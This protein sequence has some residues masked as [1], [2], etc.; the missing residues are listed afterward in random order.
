MDENLFYSNNYD[1]FNDE[2]DAYCQST[3]RGAARPEVVCPTFQVPVG[4]GLLIAGGNANIV[5]DNYF[6]D[7]WRHGTMLLWV[8]GRAARRER[9]SA[10][11][12][13]RLG[14]QPLRGQLHG[15]APGGPRPGH[16]RL[17]E[18]QGTRDPNGVDFWWDEEEGQDCDPRPGRAASTPTPASATAGAA[19]G[20]PT[21]AAMVAQPSSDPAPAAAGLPGHRPVPARQLGQ[22]GVPGSVRDLGPETNPDPPGCDW[23]TPRQEPN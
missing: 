2:R 4:T 16:D 11:T 13:T 9:P 7:N 12:T 6:W 22:A 17:L 14:Q 1:L 21:T 8:P 15:H 3:P 5:E 20:G 10:A 19:T 23:F 18:C